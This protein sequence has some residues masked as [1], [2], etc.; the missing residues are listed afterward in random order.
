[1]PPAQ[2][3]DNG[4]R[5]NR[6]TLE[7]YFDILFRNL[8]HVLFCEE[9][10]FTHGEPIGQCLQTSNRHALKRRRVVY[11]WLSKVYS[12]SECADFRKKNF[13]SFISKYN[14]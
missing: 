1:M 13:A 4:C 6:V 9:K 12:Q 11:I 10:K 8:E 3:H 14:F 7:I 2:N 5:D